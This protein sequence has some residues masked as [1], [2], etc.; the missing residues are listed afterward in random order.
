V[1]H[2]RWLLL[3]RSSCGRSVK[4]LWLAPIAVVLV[5]AAPARDALTMANPPVAEVRRVLFGQ[6]EHPD[7]VDGPPVEAKFRAD[8]CW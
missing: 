8:G 3:S 2:R 7:L 6:A 1:A 5:P 4:P